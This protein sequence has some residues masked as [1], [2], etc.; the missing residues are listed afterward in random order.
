MPAYLSEGRHP[1]SQLAASL[2]VIELNQTRP[3]TTLPEPAIPTF[4]SPRFSHV[5]NQESS[6]LQGSMGLAK[7]PTKGGPTI[8]VVKKVVEAFT[9]SR[10]YASSFISPNVQAGLNPRSIRLT[11]P[12]RYELD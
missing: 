9:R 10:L 11:C 8:P 7:Q 4:G 2:V 6:R 1:A 12:D 5:E 3:V